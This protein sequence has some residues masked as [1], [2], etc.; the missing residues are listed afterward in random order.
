MQETYSLAT[1]Y[2]HEMRELKAKLIDCSNL[3]FES[4]KMKKVVELAIKV[5]DVDSTVLISGES[6]AGKEVIAKIIH[7][8]S[9]TERA[10]YTNQLCCYP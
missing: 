10:F 5:A 2:Y 4:P 3:I 6:G 7:E 8:T 1:R 9:R